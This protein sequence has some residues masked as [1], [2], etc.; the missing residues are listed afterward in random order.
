MPVSVSVIIPCFNQGKF[1]DEAVDSVLAQSY[2]DFEIIIV[3]DGSTDAD[4]NRLLQRYDRPKTRVIT[5][6]NQGLAAARNNGIRAANGEYVLPLDADDRIGPTYLEQA[7]KLLVKR[8]E[9]G[10]VYCRAQL[11]GAV[12]TEWK[13]PEFSLETMLLDNVIFCS[14]LFRRCD[15]QAVGGYD[16]SLIHGWEDYDFWLSL[17]EKDRKVHRISETLFYYRVA[18]DSMIRARP[19]QHKLET[20]TRIYHKH[21]LLYSENIHIWIDKLLD[22][23]GQYHEA[24][25]FVQDQDSQHPDERLVRK[26]DINT[27]RLEFQLPKDYESGELIF[28]VADD[29]VIVRLNEISIKNLNSHILL[30]EWT[31]NA[32]VVEEEVF[33][34]CNDNPVF[35]LKLPED[36]TLFTASGKLVVHLEYLAFGRDCLPILLDVLQA[37]KE[38][39]A[40]MIQPVAQLNDPA[41]P[42]VPVSWWGVNKALIKLRLKSFKYYLPNKHYRTIKKSSLFD[43]GYYL[44]NDPQ[45]NPLL[46][47]PLIHYVE[48]G[49]R[50]GRNP[51]SL[52][53]ADWYRQ[54]YQVPEDRDPLLDY[55]ETGCRDGNNPHPLFLGDWYTHEYPESTIMG[56]TPLTHYI[57]EGWRNGCNP[58]PFFDLT[59]YQERHL[60]INTSHLDPLTHFVT[61]GQQRKDELFLFFDENYYLESNPSVAMKGISPFFHY[62]HYGADE[63]C[64]PNRFFNPE[65][66]QG[67]CCPEFDNPLQVFFHYTQ[68]G[69]VNFFRP[70]A[71]FDPEFYSKAYPESLAGYSHPLLHYQEQG[72]FSGNYPCREVADLQR[73]PTISILTPVFNTDEHLLRRCIHSVLYQAY[74]HWELCLVDDGSSAPHIQPLLE[75]FAARDQRI[76]VKFLDQNF[77]IAGASN[78]AATLAGGEYLGFLD[79]DDELTVDALYEMVLAVNVQD[80]DILY[81]NENLINN[82]SRYLDSFFKPDFNPEL[83]F[84]HNF[85]THFLVTR[86]SLYDQVGGLSSD[87]N[88]AQDYDLLL[89]LTEKSSRVHHI[90][91]VLYHWRATETST[92]INHTQKD[93]AN[94]AGLQA[95]QA[96]V[97]R[98]GLQADVR[99]GLMNYYYEIRR[100]PAGKPLVDIII[101]LEDGGEEVEAWLTSLLQA[102][103]YENLLV[104]LIPCGLLSP[105]TEEQLKHVDNRVTVMP[106]AA[107]GNFA[108]ALNSA[109]QSGNGEFLCFLDQGVQPKAPDWLE[110]FLG[111][112]QM[113]DTGVVGGLVINGD[114]EQEENFL[115]DIMDSSSQ[116]YH[117]FLTQ[118]SAHANGLFCPQQVVAVSS[119]FCMVKRELFVQAG[120]LD[121][122]NF[123]ALLYDVDLCFQMQDLGLYHIFTPYCK[124]TRKNNTRYS[125]NRS[126][127]GQEKI[128]FQK[129]WQQLLLEG[130]PYITTANIYGNMDIDPV[131]WIGWYAG[132]DS[133]VA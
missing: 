123:P 91:K 24:A 9:L 58:N 15:W 68:E 54:T 26:V 96:A 73:K 57:L 94:E 8:S 22:V 37:K 103:H 122:K 59:E 63:G 78:E 88:G 14:A 56:K 65:Y 110:I 52:F 19:R 120:G 38:I 28:K 51:N 126:G 47:D 71:L 108:L 98:R 49:W 44:Q 16:E 133:L 62:I 27:S 2:T 124:A 132:N 55:I 115:P 111:Y 119:E 92:S 84:C 76:K 105:D 112:A 106:Q 18:S 102:I 6:D 53:V 99:Q 116:A 79:H 130:N 20:F 125:G 101:L 75:E 64:S 90:P 34:F 21:Q 60:D 104:Y 25:L 81:S 3:N 72:I 39:P 131:G 35:C 69:S 77:G 7:V 29:Y 41:S 97:Q 82:E 74:P 128:L 43:P 13:L 33:V 1:V 5:T 31:N 86:R 67:K 83:L 95:L 121:M 12:D 89:K 85:I 11:F 113:T 46:V 48:T 50:E 17:L 100:H 117:Y 40:E 32:D 114:E 66:Y 45:M 36:D 30:K 4:T 118:A 127:N 61:F 80:P 93:Y 129:K 23:R 87:Y 109:V 10:I 70:S 107:A 42:E